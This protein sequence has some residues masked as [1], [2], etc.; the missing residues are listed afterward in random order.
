M[1]AKQDVSAPRGSILAVCLAKFFSD[2]AVESSTFL[3]AQ[4]G[5][6]ALHIMRMLQIDLLLVGL[7]LPDMSVW[8]L[9]KKV[10][11]LWPGQIWI[12]VMDNLTEQ[13]ERLARMMGASGFFHTQQ[14]DIPE[15]FR[16][17]GR[18]RTDAFDMVSL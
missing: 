7:Y 17:A 6:E 8:D 13:D 15:L 11:T 16:L 14:L 1:L 4:S 12:M 5:R 9:I 2:I 3:Q 18:I 10:R